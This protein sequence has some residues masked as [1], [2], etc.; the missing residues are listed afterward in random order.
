[1]IEGTI[2]L[3]FTEHTHERSHAKYKTTRIPILEAHS[4]QG[5]GFGH[6]E[7][8]GEKEQWYG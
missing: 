1:M 3:A 2:V 7:S 5:Q 4:S 8:V 6:A